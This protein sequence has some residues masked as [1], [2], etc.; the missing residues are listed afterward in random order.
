MLFSVTATVTFWLALVANAANAA[1]I[2]NVKPANSGCAQ[3]LSIAA[4]EWFYAIPFATL[5]FS[6]ASLN[7]FKKSLCSLPFNSRTNKLIQ[8]TNIISSNISS[9]IDIVDISNFY[10]VA[11]SVLSPTPGM[12]GTWAFP[13][14]YVAPIGA[15]VSF[16]D[17]STTW[18]IVQDFAT[19]ICRQLPVAYLI[20]AN[21]D[22]IQQSPVM[23]KLTGNGIQSANIYT[24]CL[25]LNNVGVY[26]TPTT[27]IGTLPHNLSVVYT[28]NIQTPSYGKLT[29]YRWVPGNVSAVRVCSHAPICNIFSFDGTNM[30]RQ[31]LNNGIN[32]VALLIDS[33]TNYT[34]SCMPNPICL[35]DGLYQN[36][37]F[38]TF[39]ATDMNP[40]GSSTSYFSV[41]FDKASFPPPPPSPSP[42]SPPP[43]RPSPPS[44]PSPNPPPTPPPPSCEPYWPPACDSIWQQISMLI[45]Q[46][47]A[48][49]ANITRLQQLVVAINATKRGS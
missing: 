24:G 9:N 33:F 26:F 48:L 39:V 19:A 35:N 29:G 2:T 44:P 13:G 28:P 11:A 6:S 7:T 45:E 38:T 30:T 3:Q 21:F 27:P 40:I 43:P 5:D 17:D 8:Y 31:W 36:L 10:N 34:I 49:L 14:G 46:N 37:Y 4:F 20:N 32:G 23:D 25:Q 1:N 42:P 18:N 16:S 12:Y 41:I 47:D 22:H 15:S